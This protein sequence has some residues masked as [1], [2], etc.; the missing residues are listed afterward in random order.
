M[1][2]IAIQHCLVIISVF[3]SVLAYFGSVVLRGHK[4]Q[5]DTCSKSVSGDNSR[6]NV[7]KLV[8]GVGI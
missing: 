3:S 7:S 6:E 2:G 8:V 5:A 1:L 4:P